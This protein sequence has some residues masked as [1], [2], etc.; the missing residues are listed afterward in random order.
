L[1][2]DPTASDLADRKVLADGS[3]HRDKHGLSDICEAAR[4]SALARLALPEAT[5][6]RRLLTS[7]A[8]TPR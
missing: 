2:L 5:R 6:A 1:V 4:V 7:A 3:S 8:E